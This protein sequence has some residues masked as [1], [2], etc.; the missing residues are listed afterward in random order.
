VCNNNKNKK[1]EENKPKELTG[2]GIRD[3]DFRPGTNKEKRFQ[4]ESMIK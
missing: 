2:N 3:F 1:G 4:V